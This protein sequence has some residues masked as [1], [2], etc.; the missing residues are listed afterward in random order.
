MGMGRINVWI[1]GEGDPCGVSEHPF[2]NPT[3]WQVAVWECSGRLLQW[4]GRTY[5]GIPARCGHA[6]IEVPPGRYIVRAAIA[7]R[8][9]FLGNDWTD[10]GIVTVGCDES[11]CLTLYAPSAHTCGLGY[12]RVI[13][14]LMEIGAIDRGIGERA[15][16][17]LREVVAQLP[18]TS[19]EE[20][21]EKTM[22]ELVDAAKR[23]PVEDDATS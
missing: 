23:G 14:S 8:E 21:S 18:P 20:A 19:F 5:F 3:P 12:I 15:V 9:G 7:M 6:E 13:G 4:C 17:T 10:H 11:A 2:D 1:T 22:A 16:A